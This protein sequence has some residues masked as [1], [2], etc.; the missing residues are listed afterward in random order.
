MVANHPVMRE[1]E[2]VIAFLTVEMVGAGMDSKLVIKSTDQA[3][4]SR[5]YSHSEKKHQYHM[6]KS[7]LI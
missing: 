2:S 7:L 5:I 3:F 1:D 4:T 6:T